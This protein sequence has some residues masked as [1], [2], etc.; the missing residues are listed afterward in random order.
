MSSPSSSSNDKPLGSVDGLCLGLFLF[1]QGITC[2][3][4]DYVLISQLHHNLSQCL[5]ILSVNVMSLSTGVRLGGQMV[6]GKE[7]KGRES[8][9]IPLP[10][11]Q[12]GSDHFS[13][14]RPILS[15]N[16]KST[17]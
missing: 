15:I 5:S 11:P 6:E 1:C 7:G 8:D 4:F 13:S 9:D 14:G 12:R 2:K 3:C 17:K 10:F 16:I